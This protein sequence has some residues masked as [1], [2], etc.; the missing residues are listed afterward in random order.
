MHEEVHQGDVLKIER[1]KD[2]VLVTSKNFFNM[3][4]E[5]LG[6]P[7]FNKSTDSPLHIFVSAK[8]VDGYVQCEKLALI[9][10]NVRGYKRIGSILLRDIMNIVDAIQGIFD[11]V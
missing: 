3:S 9:D 7:I 8:E 1:I 5:I 2:P 6:C 10:L 4:G 11:Y